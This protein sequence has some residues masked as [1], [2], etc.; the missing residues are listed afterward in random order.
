LPLAPEER[1]EVPLAEALDGSRELTLKRESAHLA[2]GDDREACLLL[3]LE[4]V[5]DRLVLHPLERG[6]RQLPLGELLL[7][8]E[9]VWRAK[10]TPDD[11]RSR[12][13][14]DLTLRTPGRLRGD[15]RWS[16]SCCQ[17]PATLSIVGCPARRHRRRGAT[18][19][20]IARLHEL[21]RGGGEGTPPRTFA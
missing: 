5:V 2:V 17:H 8:C 19:V 1:V 18:T 20:E 9:Q 12:V 6:G 14:H 16:A 3:E 13:E 15:P 7:R 4:G 10:K 21:I 11:V